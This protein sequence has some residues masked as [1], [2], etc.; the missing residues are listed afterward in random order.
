MT[1][2]GSGLGWTDRARAASEDCARLAQDQ[3]DLKQSC[4]EQAEALRWL[5]TEHAWYHSAAAENRNRLRQSRKAVAD[6]LS[7]Q[8]PAWTSPL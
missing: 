7:T 1:D 5:R 3:R 2:L 8:R 6:R 4:W